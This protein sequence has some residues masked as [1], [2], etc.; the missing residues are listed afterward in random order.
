MLII[1]ETEEVTQVLKKGEKERKLIAIEFV[2][3]RVSITRAGL[4]K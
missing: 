3:E 4:R 2:L 1:Q